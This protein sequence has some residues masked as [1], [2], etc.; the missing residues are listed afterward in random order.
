[1]HAFEPTIDNAI[2]DV[3][4]IGGAGDEVDSSEVGFDM[5]VSMDVDGTA[6]QSVGSSRGVR[7]LVA[8]ATGETGAATTPSY[9][10]P[11]MLQDVYVSKLV[12]FSPDKERWMKAKIY[13]PIGTAYIIGRV[14]RLVKKGTNFALP[15][16]L[17]G[18][19]V[20]ECCGAHQCRGGAA[21]HQELRSANTS[22]EPGLED[23]GST[24]S[25]R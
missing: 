14:Y 16:S 11:I 24:R 21:W 7:G 3:V 10:P 2:S 4:V 6:G 8:A 22:K 9:T 18:Q 23:T 19:P 15:D 17:A 5:D 12:A 13:R 25:Y 1:M 20:P